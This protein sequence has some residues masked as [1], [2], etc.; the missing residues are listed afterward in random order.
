M[1]AEEQHE[2][3]PGRQA[4][5]PAAGGPGALPAEGRA[6]KADVYTDVGRGMNGN[7]KKSSISTEFTLERLR[8]QTLRLTFLQSFVIIRPEIFIILEVKGGIY[9][10]V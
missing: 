7:V 10:A 1:G 2:T 8:K 3:P 6:G 4:R 9:E 5:Q